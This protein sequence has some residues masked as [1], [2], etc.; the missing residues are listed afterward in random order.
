MSESMRADKK[1]VHMLS[2]L[3]R[4]D[5][6]RLHY[7]R[8]KEQ[9]ESGGPRTDRGA[10]WKA[11]CSRSTLSTAKKLFQRVVASGNHLLVQVKANQLSLRRTLEHGASWRKPLGCAIS[12]AQSYS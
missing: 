8:G 1:A 3:R 2:A 6:A 7:G 9:R 5:R 11:A 12:Q 4:P 10:D